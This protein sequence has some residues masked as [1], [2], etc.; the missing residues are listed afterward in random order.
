MSL[1]VQPSD[2]VGALNGLGAIQDPTG[3]VLSFAG[4]SGDEQ[5]SGVPTW[6]WCLAVLAVGVY[7]GVQVAPKLRGKR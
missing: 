2:V 7:T 1:Q 6:A 3:T 4:L 5:R